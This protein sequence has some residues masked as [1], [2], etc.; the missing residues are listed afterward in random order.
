MLRI[1]K[2]YVNTRLKLFLAGECS[3][4][5]DAWYRNGQDA[6]TMF[7]QLLCAQCKIL[8]AMSNVCQTISNS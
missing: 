1:R 5:R 6:S 2:T 3:R 4:L 8:I 7:A